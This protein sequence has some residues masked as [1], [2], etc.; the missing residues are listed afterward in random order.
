MSNDRDNRPSLDERRRLVRRHRQAAVLFPLLLAACTQLKVDPFPEPLRPPREGPADAVAPETVEPRTELRIESTPGV[1]LQQSLAEGAADRLGE[2]LAG[3]P[4]E[5]SFHDLPLVTFI[6]EVFGER[7]GMSFVVAPGLAANA[8]SVTL[9]LTEPL[10]PRRLFHLAR[11]VLSEY[12][13]TLR[14]DDG[15]LTFAPSE[16]VATGGVPVIT[17]GGRTLPR[18]PDSHRTIFHFVPLKVTNGQAIED[19]LDDAFEDQDLEIT[20]SRDRGGIL[21]KGRRAL[22]EQA[23]AIIEVLD[24]PLLRSRLAAILHPAFLEA[25][26]LAQEL[27]RVL[28]AEGYAIGINSLAGSSIFLTI[29]HLNKIIVFAADRAAL[30]HIKAWAEILDDQRQESIEE[31]WFTYEVRNTQAEAVATTLNLMLGGRAGGRRTP[32]GTQAAAGQGGTQGDT[33]VSTFAGGLVVDQN[34][35]MILF[36]GSGREWGEIL[37]VIE[38]LDRPVPSVLIEVIMAEVTLS[39]IEGSGFDFL[40]KAA[41]DRYGITGGTRG[42]LGVRSSGLSATFDS[43]GE[44]RAVM[45][46]FY[47]DT[48]VVIRSRPRILVKSGQTASIEVGNEIPVITQAVDSGTETGG[49]TNILQQ[50]SYRKTGVQMDITPIVQASGRV[51]LE[52]S[53][54]LSEARP[55][56]A[57]S[58]DGSPTILNRQ[59]TTSLTLRDG[60]A[61]LMG[62]LITG[63]RS[64]GDT[65]VPGIARLPVVG[66]LFRSDSYQEDRTELMIM[67]IPYVVTD[68]EEG[69]DLTE[70][71]KEQLELH[72]QFMN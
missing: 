24:Q 11:N 18:I 61:L 21:L 60:G 44:T 54:S 36:R 69:W 8:D 30:E 25:R 6:N 28:T 5:V 63:T 52:I 2:Q 20:N 22:I 13:I 48:R 3:P 66:R 4:I 59:I 64:S 26:L 32:S 37:A 35:N 58:L 45:G 46:L 56:A 71:M 41:L 51:D 29:E 65:G 10:A 33:G 17:T 57:T 1:V 39:D 42:V 47:E 23:I 34:R 16:D 9:R 50:V 55:T 43:G 15:I 27:N 12:G 62:G 38:V 14:E 67:V 31:A 72:E 19:V 40:L 7:L 49:A 53:Q 70:R 68:H